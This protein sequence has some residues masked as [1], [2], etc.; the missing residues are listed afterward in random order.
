M[1]T[2]SEL[3]NY[4]KKSKIENKEKV[5]KIINIINSIPEEKFGDFL[6]EKNIST[7]DDVKKEFNRINMPE[8]Q[9]KFD[10]LNELV[11]FGKSNNTIHIHLIPKDARFLFNREGLKKAE[12]QLIDS[13]EKINEIVSSNEEYKDVKQ[14]YA[15]SGIIKPP[16]SNM[17]K[18]L[19]FDVKI[20]KINE[21]K[22]DK[23]LGRFYELFKDKKNLGRA[24]ISI[25]KLKT[26]EWNDKKNHR[27]E[28]LIDIVKQVPNICS[29]VRKGQ[30]ESLDCIKQIKNIEEKGI[31]NKDIQI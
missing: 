8:T 2:K 13:I 26:Q 16:I 17:F 3:L 23:E 12:L 6:K 28:E 14:I 29:N 4:I 19:D 9:Q 1:I 10:E 7:M 18:N 27:K 21:A 31:S 22:N 24:V 30:I 20:M 11:M 25:E 5:E 15:V